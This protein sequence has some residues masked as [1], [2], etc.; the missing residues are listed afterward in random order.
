MSG[1]TGKTNRFTSTRRFRILIPSL[2]IIFFLGKSIVFAQTEGGRPKG[3]LQIEFG[4]DSLERKFYRP[5]FS[6]AG[7]LAFDGRSLA[8]LDLSYLQKINGSLE[9][10][11]DFWI[12]TGIETRLSGRL[13]LEASLNHFCRH[14]TSLFSPSILNLNELVGRIWVRNDGLRAGIGFGVYVGGSPGYDGLLLLNL[15]AP[16]ILI[17]E[18]SL[19]SELKWVNFAEILHETTF[20]IALTPG[21]DLIIAAAKQYHLPRTTHLGL[22]FRPEGSNARLLDGFNMAVGA[23]P[24]FDAYKLMV[25]GAFR[26]AFLREPS[27]RFFLDIDFHSPV[28]S[29]SEFWGQFWPDR[30][31][32]T[33]SA[34]YERPVGN[35]YLAW[36]GRYFADLPVDKAVPF[37]ASAATGLALRNLPDF[38]RLDGPVRFE[39]RAGFDLKFKY[40]IGAKLGINTMGSSGLK[41]GA[42]A[43]VDIN[44]ERRAAEAVIFAAYGRDVS[45]RPFAGIRQV[46]P[47]AGART[48][49]ESFKR[50]LTAGIAFHKW[51]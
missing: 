2:L 34:E 49:D 12:R 45:V 50:I 8:F 42:E 29:G 20:A 32:Y 39:I 17:P 36:Y 28:L 19:E 51:F 11:I 21:T 4:L 38:D 35:F 1:S 22:R 47:L 25:A 14:Q 31:F 46:K 6:L 41:A 13:S 9:G 5:E 10:P 27:R 23:Y 7:P 44:A 26:L 18:L 48:P 43:R 33:I 16:H 30:M 40:D 24:F 15:E 37:R 3:T